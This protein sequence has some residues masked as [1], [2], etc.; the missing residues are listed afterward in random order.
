MICSRQAG[1]YPARGYAGYSRFN[2]GLF[3]DVPGCVLC[4]RAL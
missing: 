4:D 2:D 1:R 3:Y